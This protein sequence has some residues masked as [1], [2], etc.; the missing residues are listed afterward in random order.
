MTTCAL[1]VALVAS[2]PLPA[3]AETGSSAGQLVPQSF[4]TPSMPPNG[5]RGMNAAPPA[6]V[7]PGASGSSLLIGNLIVE[8]LDP[9]F[10]A[11]A[12]AL[13]AP[14]RGRKRPV[15]DI[16]D[17]AARI[18]KLYSD[19]GSFLTRVIIPPQNVENGGTVT[20]KVI[21][22]FIADIDVT[23]VAPQVRDRL[24]RL[25]APLKHRPGLAFGAFER[26]LLLAS[27]TA[28]VKLKTNLKPAEQA[29]GV[30]LTVSGD[31]DPLG[32]QIMTDNGLSSTLGTYQ[33]TLST[34]LNTP[35][36]QGEQI[37]L[38]ATGSPTN[39]GLGPQSVRRV[40]AIGA[41]IPLAANGLSG[42]LEYTWSGTRPMVGKKGLATSSRYQRISA[43]V[44]YPVI[45]DQSSRL[46]ASIGYDHVDELN[47]AIDFDYTLYHDR[48]DVL[49]AGI[50][51]SR[52]F[53]GGIQFS[54]GLDLSLGLSGLFNSK[55]S[56]SWEGDPFSKLQ[57]RIHVFREFDNGVGLDLNARGQYSATGR[58][59]N[60]EKFVIGGAAD[61]SGSASGGWSGD[62]GWSLRSEIQYDITRY[63]DRPGLA[64]KSYLFAARGHVYTEKP[65][66][67]ELAMD[68]ATGFGVG[69]RG[70]WASTRFPADP[71][72][73]LLEAARSVSDHPSGHPD[74]WRVNLSIGVRF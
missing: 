26:A 30:T 45:L 17:L 65:T 21:E 62:H 3:L 16:Y 5:P 23:A 4:S 25:F 52:S 43:K 11:E 48:L 36:G 41:N 57:A 8:G 12:D 55:G 32:G 27:G 29:L 35:L 28:G 60:A 15:S 13:I 44:S 61:L 19:D 6:V 72:D 73:F 70:Q 71:V 18:Q 42:N 68:G 10:T 64:L 14:L 40:F 20:L 66:F 39:G 49:R 54:G 69:L 47:R 59:K 46:S 31:Y 51:Y 38:S 1:L 22:G 34:S 56:H 58:L 63:F 37:Y 2:G 50:D 53:L 74:E 33:T 67:G 24:L 7:P 9:R